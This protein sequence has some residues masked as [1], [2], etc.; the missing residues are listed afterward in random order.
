MSTSFY[1]TRKL[2]QEEIDKCKKLL[3]EQNIYELI[4]SLPVEKEIC[5]RAG[6][7]QVLWFA[8]NFKYF[9]QNAKSLFN[10][11]KNSIITDEYG[12]QYSFEEFYKE[13]KDSL[14]EGETFMSYYQD[15]SHENFIRYYE[16]IEG[17]VQNQ[18]GEFF[19]DGLRF[20]NNKD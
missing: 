18:Y 16:F 3:D 6:G 2:S 10:F 8:H 7:W 12:K 1:V 19:I 15:N 14:Y 11:L 5:H 4:N 17:I 13:I 9:N 20:I